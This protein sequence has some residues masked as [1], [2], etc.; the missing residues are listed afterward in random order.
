[1]IATASNP[2]Y[3]AALSLPPDAREE[4]IELLLT[5]LEFPYDPAV[6]AAN[7]EE[8]QRRRAAYQKGL[9]PTFT[10]DEVLGPHLVKK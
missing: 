5:S 10:R 6:H 7:L 2:I 8:V 3:D 4:L 1:M 9:T